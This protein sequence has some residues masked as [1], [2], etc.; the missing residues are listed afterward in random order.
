M[1][2]VPV[3]LRFGIRKSQIQSLYYY[4]I[5]FPG[6]TYLGCFKD[7]GDRDMVYLGKLNDQTVEKC[8]GLCKEEASGWVDGWSG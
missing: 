4:T 3:F 7:A 1:Y 5:I 2:Q 8:V 6:G